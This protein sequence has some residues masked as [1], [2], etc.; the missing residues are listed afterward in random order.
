MKHKPL[1]QPGR[2]DPPRPVSPRPAPKPK[3][4]K[5]PPRYSVDDVVTASGRHRISILHA[6]Q[7]GELGGTQAA[8]GCRWF[9]TENDLDDWLARG[10][11]ITPAKR[12]R[13]LHAV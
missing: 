3:G 12:K 5:G 11:P 4:P 9:I 13:R 1:P 10:A 6:L 2:N 8:P 7:S